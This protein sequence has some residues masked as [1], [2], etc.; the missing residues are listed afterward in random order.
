MSTNCIR[1]VVKKRTGGDLLCDSCRLAAQRPAPPPADD[2]I[3]RPVRV[4]DAPE[5]HDGAHI[6]D[7][8]DN[9]VPLRVVVAALNAPRPACAQCAVLEEV[10]RD[11]GILIAEVREWRFNASVPSEARDFVTLDK[12][13][14]E[15][16]ARID[17]VTPAPA[18]EPGGGK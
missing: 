8:T 13:R 1:C 2:G 4:A 10:L 16:D 18:K 14:R 15:T 12:R 9:W 11:K 17:I 3:K 5:V 7:A 6:R